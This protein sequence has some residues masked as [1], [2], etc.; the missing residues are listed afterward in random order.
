MYEIIYTA[1]SQFKD[2]SMRQVEI[3][4]MFRYLRNYC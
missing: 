4:A 2:T 1:G 3:L